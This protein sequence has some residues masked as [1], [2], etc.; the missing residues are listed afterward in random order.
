MPDTY[1]NVAMRCKTCN[2]RLWN[3]AGR[4]C[5]ECGT[6]FRPSGFEIEVVHNP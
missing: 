1:E 3:L 2:Y 4:T 6:G 5:P